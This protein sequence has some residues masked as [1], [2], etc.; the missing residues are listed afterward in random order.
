[1]LDPEPAEPQGN[2]HGDALKCHS[3]LP[4]I[5]LTPQLLQPFLLVTMTDALGGDWEGESWA[6]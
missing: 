2:F 4:L 1:M 5:S 6:D 3:S